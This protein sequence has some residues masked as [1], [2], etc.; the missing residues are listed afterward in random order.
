MPRTG[1]STR[2]AT[3][4]FVS[5]NWRDQKM[6]FVSPTGLLKFVGFLP[7]VAEANTK[8]ERLLAQSTDGALHLLG[9]FINWRLR[10]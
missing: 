1:C 2:H 6:N 5:C 7:L 9:N 10:F 3:F 4:S 8:L